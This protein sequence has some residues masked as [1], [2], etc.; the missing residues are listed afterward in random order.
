MFATF[1]VCELSKHFRT[2]VINTLYE[3]TENQKT[4][5]IHSNLSLPFGE[6]MVA[7]S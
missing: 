6:G 7:E 1:N 3:S 4:A 5:K 2:R